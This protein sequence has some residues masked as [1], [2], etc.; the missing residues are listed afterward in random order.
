MCIHPQ[1]SFIAVKGKDDNLMIYFI[2]ESQAGERERERE[3][4]LA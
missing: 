4:A 3:R 2:S 1:N